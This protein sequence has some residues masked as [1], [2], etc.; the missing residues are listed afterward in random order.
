MASRGSVACRDQ[1]ATTTARGPRA[2][3]I[4]FRAPNKLVGSSSTTNLEEPPG[5]K[6]R[7]DGSHT[8]EPPPLPVALRSP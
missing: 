1:D 2:T 5:I 7:G 3:G 8:T 6:A 4:T